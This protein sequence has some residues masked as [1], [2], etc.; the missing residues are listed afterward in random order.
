LVLL[1]V[2]TPV[3]AQDFRPAGVNFGFGVAF[4]VGPSDFKN[5]FET[6]WNGGAGVTFNVSPLFGVQAEYMYF[7]F[8]GPDRT[9]TVFPTPG[10]PVGESA[11]I[12]S[13]HQMH[14]VTFN[15][16]YSVGL[17]T[18][19]PVGVYVLGGPGYYHRLVQLTTPAVGYTT[20]CDPYW[21][22]CYP[23]LTSVDQIIG[24]RSSNDFGINFGAGVTFGTDVK[25]YVEGRYHYVWGPEVQAQVPV[26]SGGPCQ[27]EACSTNAQYFPLTFGVRW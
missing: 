2:A 8:G 9:I 10:A 23:A 6:G 5:D 15:A 17:S 1:A 27:V 7:R 12:E 25:F 13:N 3:S 4:P 18:D 24:D 14:T 22:V 26:V 11:L 16:V 19:R 21:L 20:I